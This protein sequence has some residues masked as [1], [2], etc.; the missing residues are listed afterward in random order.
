MSRLQGKIALITGAA[1]GLGL[2]MAQRFA[3][4]GA[5]VLLTDID[6]EGAAKA[7]REIGGKAAAF[8]HDVTREDQWIAA[9]EEC[10]RLF[11]GLHI[12]VNN[13]GI[14]TPGTVEDTSL[15]DWRRVHAIDLDGV[16]L[17][18]KHA[19]PLIRETTRREGSR[20][21][22]LNISSIAGVIASGRMAAYN[23]AKAGVR[24]L[25]KSVALHCASS[26][27][28]ITCNS[29]HPTF[30]DTPILDNFQ[31]AGVGREEVKAKLGRQVPLGVIG[32]PDDVAWG[33]VYLCSDEAR[34]VTGAELFIDGGISAM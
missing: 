23:S 8:R 32:E 25:T 12:L 20:G 14:G 26:R 17:G 31:S 24:H 21:S 19:I 28:S 4:Q 10:R 22:I 5:Q 15:E 16:F 6:A 3:E 1:S 7:A 13:A 33:A 2:R 30:M 34:F 9:V 27:D 11:G 18:C 29:I